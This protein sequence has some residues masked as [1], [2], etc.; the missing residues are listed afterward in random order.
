M[1]LR[2]LF[3]RLK[4]QQHMVDAIEESGV[5]LTR[6]LGIS[7]AQGPVAQDVHRMLE[8]SANLPDVEIDSQGDRPKNRT[9]KRKALKPKS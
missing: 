5:D 8:E 1:K 9:S 2:K 7:N 3:I 6:L 4:K